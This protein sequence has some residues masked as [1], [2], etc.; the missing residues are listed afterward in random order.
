MAGRE[1]GNTATPGTGATKRCALRA[2]SDTIMMRRQA[3][4]RMTL[5]GAD[6]EREMQRV[7]FR[8]KT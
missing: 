1:F 6:D 4:V 3:T 2:E 5:V 8:D 7:E